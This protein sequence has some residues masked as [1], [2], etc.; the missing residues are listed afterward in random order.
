MPADSDR[1]RAAILA[2]ALSPLMAETGEDVALRVKARLVLAELQPALAEYHRM[3]GETEPPEVLHP[4]LVE[5]VVPGLVNEQGRIVNRE[6]L[7]GAVA[8]LR[9]MTQ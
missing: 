2:A 9:W 7:E 3:N 4:P 1:E 6:R 8:V 5:A